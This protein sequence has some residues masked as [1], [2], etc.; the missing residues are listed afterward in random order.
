MLSR[1]KLFKL[2]SFNNILMT[3]EYCTVRTL[4]RQR[5]TDCLI[6]VHTGH[7]EE[8]TWN[9]PCKKNQV[10]QFAEDIYVMLAYEHNVMHIATNQINDCINIREVFNLYLNTFEQILTLQSLWK[11]KCVYCK[12]V[13]TCMLFA[14]PI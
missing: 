5:V 4:V 10:I 2:P 3:T 11:M 12:D 6:W 14:I 13:Q 9:L 8:T 1:D 7:M